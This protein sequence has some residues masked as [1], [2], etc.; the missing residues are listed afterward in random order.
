MLADKEG[1]RILGCF[2]RSN[3]L[4]GQYQGQSGSLEPFSSLLGMVKHKSL[5]RYRLLT[6]NQGSLNEHAAQAGSIHCLAF[7]QS[8]SL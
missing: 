5:D 1:S 8:G 7:W 6:K 4:S 2:V 3:G